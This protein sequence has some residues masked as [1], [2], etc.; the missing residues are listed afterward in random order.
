MAAEAPNGNHR[1]LA[2]WQ[3][4][5]GRGPRGGQGTAEEVTP[6]AQAADGPCDTV[7]GAIESAGVDVDMDEVTP[8]P[9]P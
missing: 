8:T 4:V 9:F 3:D 1:L 6:A 7:L 2:I 5:T